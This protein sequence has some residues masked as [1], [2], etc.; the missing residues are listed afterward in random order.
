MIAFLTAKVIL[1]GFTAESLMY[2]TYPMY[3]RYK[4]PNRT[5]C[6]LEGRIVIYYNSFQVYETLHRCCMAMIYFSRILVSKSCPFQ[7]YAR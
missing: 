7:V 2:H 4:N 3:S 5:L 6:E 1:P